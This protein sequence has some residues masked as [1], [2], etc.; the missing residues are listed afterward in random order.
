MLQPKGFT[1]MEQL[2]D[3]INIQQQQAAKPID[4]DLSIELID[5]CIKDVKAIRSNAQQWKEMRPLILNNLTRVRSITSGF[6]GYIKSLEDTRK[7]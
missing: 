7:A 6:L 3:H 1:T 2:P 4:T 5:C